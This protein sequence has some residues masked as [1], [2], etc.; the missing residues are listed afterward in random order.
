MN[1]SLRILKLITTEELVGEVEEEKESSI[2]IK[3]PCLL[4]IGM[5]STGKASLQMTPYLLFSEQKV[6]EFKKEHVLCN[7]S[8]ATEIQNK[9]NEIYGTGIVVAKN[10]SIIV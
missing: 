3:N 10:Q 1:D 6:V 9:Y 4:S 2:R 7:V 8:V 5:S